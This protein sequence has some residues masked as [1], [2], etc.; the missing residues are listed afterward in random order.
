MVSSTSP[1]FRHWYNQ[2]NLPCTC[3]SGQQM[4]NQSFQQ[5]HVLG[6]VLISYLLGCRTSHWAAARRLNC[7]PWSLQ[8]NCSGILDPPICWISLFLFYCGPPVGCRTAGSKQLVHNTYYGMLMVSQV[9]C[10]MTSSNWLT[11]WEV[12]ILESCLS[13]IAERNAETLMDPTCSTPACLSLR[14]LWKSCQ[15][16]LIKWWENSTTWNNFC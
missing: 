8:N 3:P 4:H 14:A 10:F 1:H 13:K 7:R 9:W 5:G 12:I 15:S 16:N 6:V 11:A 2:S